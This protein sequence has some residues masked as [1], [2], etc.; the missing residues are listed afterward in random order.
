MYMNN[1]IPISGG[2]F[3]A[4]F[5][6]IC[7]S[8]FV[9]FWVHLFGKFQLLINEIICCIVAYEPT[10]QSL[11]SNGV[12]TRVATCVVLC[13]ETK[14]VFIQIS[15]TINKRHFSLALCSFEFLLESMAKGLCQSI[16]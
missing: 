15:R 13:L 5:V 9:S 2:V 16:E 12:L 8:Y 6:Y 3:V 1:V 10:W 4:F 11:K 7:I 14:T